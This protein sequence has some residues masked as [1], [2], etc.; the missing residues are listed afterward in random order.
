METWLDTTVYSEEVFDDFGNEF[1]E[2]M[3]SFIDRYEKRYHTS[4]NNFLLISERDSFYGDWQPYAGKIGYRL[5][6][7]LDEFLVSSDD[8]KIYVGDDKMIHFDYFD[9]DGANYSVVKL[10][11]GSVEEK[12]YNEVGCY[13]CELDY[14]EMLQKRGQLKPTKFWR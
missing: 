14:V 3:E 1:L 12:V 8:I 4:V 11:P 6:Q 9:H 10:I 7:D 5:I 2:E 13:A